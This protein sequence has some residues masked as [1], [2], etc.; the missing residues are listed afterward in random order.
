MPQI[1]EQQKKILNEMEATE[2]P[3]A[4][5]KIVVIRMLKDLKE[6]MDLSENLKKIASME[7][8]I[9]TIKKKPS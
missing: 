3:H 9:E 8:D 4:K 2:I 5:F 1:K 7:K 6:R